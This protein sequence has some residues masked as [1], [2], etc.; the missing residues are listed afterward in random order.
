M[1]KTEKYEFQK[2][3]SKEEAKKHKGFH[4]TVQLLGLL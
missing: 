4:I 3:L 1:N 2:E